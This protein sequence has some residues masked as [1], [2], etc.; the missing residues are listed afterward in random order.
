MESLKPT[1]RAMIDD[2]AVLVFDHLAASAETM[3]LDEMFRA[4]PFSR[5]E[6][7]RKETM[8]YKHWVREIGLD[9]VE[10]LGIYQASKHV[11]QSHFEGGPFRCFRAYCNA[12][13]Y[14]DMLITHRD[15][16][17]KDKNVVTALWYICKSWDLEW[18]GETLF[19]DKQQETA[20]AVNPKPGRM[21][22]FE[23]SL[24]HVG[25]PPNR[26]CTEPR[27]TLALKFLREGKKDE[28]T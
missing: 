18:G 1:R 27:Y 16:N 8:Q 24:L 19:F 25:R 22:I 21:A 23:G 2:Q 4:S 6:F 15:C 17:P 13:Y 14:G 20:F 3:A 12:A 28:E 5:T 11:V 26:I 9:Q 7:A 10:S